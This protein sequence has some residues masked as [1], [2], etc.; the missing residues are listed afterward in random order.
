VAGRNEALNIVR[1]IESLSRIKYPEDLLEI[2][3]VNDNSTDNTFE[4]MKESSKNF[5]FFKVI[6]SA[7]NS[8]GNLKGKAN[9]IDTAISQ[10]TGDII[11]S[12]DADCEVSPDWV[13]ESVKYFS[14]NTAM[15]CGF[16]LI[17]CGD[18]LFSK[19]QS[20][21]W[22]YLL[23]LASSSSGLKLILSCIGNNLAFTK[24]SYNDIGGYSAVGFSVT[25]DLALMR[26]INSYKKYQIKYPVDKDCIVETLACSDLAELFSQKRRWFRGGI[27]I[28]FLG[29]II[30][31]ELYAMNFLLI[32]GYLFMSFQAYLILIIIKTISEMILIS[33]IIKRFKLGYLYKYYP[34]FCI[35][36]ALYGMTLPFT[37]LSG[38]KI[39]WKGQKF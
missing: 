21:D 33:G 29:Y 4:L 39:K 31:A 30:G 22:I 25:E 5:S 34:L 24:S 16:T 1:C 14:G 11:V 23:A 3:L 37:F 17:K 35:Y 19:M 13:K 32:F 15:V 28:N 18:S 7:K 9:A 2:I 20:I 12:T 36:F 10:C 8:A 27:G 38:T 6:N 26:K